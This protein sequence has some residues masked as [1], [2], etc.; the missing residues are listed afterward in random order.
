MSFLKLVEASETNDN[1]I[2]YLNVVISYI[3]DNLEEDI[4]P[5]HVADKVHLS[6]GYLMMLFRNFLG[7]SIMEYT[8]KMRIHKSNELLR[9]KNL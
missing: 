4:T 8:Y 7:T 1:I 2:E 6:S 3:N 9:N 5:Q